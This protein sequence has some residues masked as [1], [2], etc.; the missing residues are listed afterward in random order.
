MM[1]EGG[2]WGLSPAYDLTG[3]VPPE[4][5]EGDARRDWTNCHA[6]SINGKQSNIMDDDLLE[7]GARYSIGTAESILADIKNVFK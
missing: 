1:C 7:I 3:G 2:A 4:A 6:M 5:P